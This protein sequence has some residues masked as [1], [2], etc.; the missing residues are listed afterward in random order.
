MGEDSGASE[1]KFLHVTLRNVAHAPSALNCQCVT[2]CDIEEEDHVPSEATKTL[3]LKR[4]SETSS[5]VVSYATSLGIKLRYSKGR[6][7]GGGAR[8]NHIR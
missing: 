8:L 5:G 2:E 3:I 7:G 4:E 1:L 6:R